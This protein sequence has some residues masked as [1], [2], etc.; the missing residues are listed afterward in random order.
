MYFFCYILISK[1]FRIIEMV[2]DVFNPDV[3][4]CQCGAD[5]LAGDP[6]SCGNLTHA[7]LV[8]CVQL[9]L[10][11]RCPTVLLGGGK[12]SAFSSV[13]SIHKESGFS[14]DS[15]FTSFS[16][17]NITGFA[18]IH[19]SPWRSP[20]ADTQRSP[21]LWHVHRLLPHWFFF[22]WCLTGATNHLQQIFRC[23]LTVRYRFNQIIALKSPPPIS[24]IYSTV[25]CA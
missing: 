5:A 24:S 1:H 25:F 3:V 18:F 23:W 7:S 21:F 6:L 9:L 12:L 4:V 8:N 19:A 2:K 16:L 15:I 10:S 22:R 13:L 17:V 11:L 14:S 20:Q